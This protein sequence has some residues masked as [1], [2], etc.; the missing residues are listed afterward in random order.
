MTHRMFYNRRKVDT[1]MLQNIVF[2]SKAS[3]K[4]QCLIIKNGNTKEAQE[5]YEFLI[6]DMPELPAIDPVPPTWQENTRDTVKGVVS[7]LQENQTSIA[8][9]AEYLKKLFSKSPIATPTAD[10]LPPIN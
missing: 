3:L 4:Q 9:A 7:W 5:L 8:Q 6:S 2:T 1:K 10:A